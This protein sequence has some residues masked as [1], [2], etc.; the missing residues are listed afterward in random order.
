MPPAPRGAPSTSTPEPPRSTAAA[1]RS[2]A[3]SSPAGSSTWATIADGP[4]RPRAVHPQPAPRHRPAHRSRARRRAHRARL[5]RGPRRGPGGRGQRAVRAA[6]LVVRELL[7][8]RAG[9]AHGRS[10]EHTSELQSLMR[11]SYAVFCLKN[12][13]KSNKYLITHTIL[14]IVRTLI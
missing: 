12:K 4:R 8:D 3:T 7:R 9:A 1:P 6:G 13:T 11:I 2:S 14:H 5:E 10:E